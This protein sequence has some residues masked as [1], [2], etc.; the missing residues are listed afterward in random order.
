MFNEI[1]FTKIDLTGQPPAD[2]TKRQYYF[3]LSYSQQFVYHLFGRI[4]S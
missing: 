3:I 2:E 1:D 4:N